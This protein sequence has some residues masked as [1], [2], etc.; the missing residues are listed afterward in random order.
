MITKCPA[1]QRRSKAKLLDHSVL[2]IEFNVKSCTLQQ[3]RDESARR[4]DCEIIV[5]ILRHSAIRPPNFWRREEPRSVCST[6]IC[7]TTFGGLSTPQSGRRLPV[8]TGRLK[9]SFRMLRQGDN[10]IFTVIWYGQQKVIRP[11]PRVTT[12]GAIVDEFILRANPVI[13]QAL[14]A[15]LDAV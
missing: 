14:Q 6:I 2:S 15:A 11:R 13:G 4:S 12:R 5:G 3:R 10:A 1:W 9:R 7:T 8:R